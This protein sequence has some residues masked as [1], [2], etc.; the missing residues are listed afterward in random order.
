MSEKIYVPG[1]RTFDAKEDAPD[2]ALGSLII[3]P[4][5]FLEWLKE[6][7]AEYLTEYKGTKQLRLNVTKSKKG[8]GVMVS[9]NTYKPK[10]QMP[11]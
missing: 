6:G 2:F 8:K 11:F 10:E 7:G 4:K 5:P 9:V 3:E 1:I